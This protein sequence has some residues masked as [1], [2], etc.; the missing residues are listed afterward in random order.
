MS[1]QLSNYSCFC[2]PCNHRCSGVNDTR[3]SIASGLPH[4]FVNDTRASMATGMA[5]SVLLPHRLIFFTR[6]WLAARFLSMTWCLF[7]YVLKYMNT[8][9][10]HTRY[11]ILISTT[12][13][14]S[15]FSEWYITCN[16]LIFY[17]FI[18]DNDILGIL[19]LTLIRDLKMDFIQSR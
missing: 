15:I 3:A 7:W 16:R 2:Q 5:R 11:K 12:W 1:S 19:S 18:L 14:R 9:S 6:W 10:L 4:L 13:V 17:D 8:L